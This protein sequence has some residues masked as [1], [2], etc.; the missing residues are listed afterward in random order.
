MDGNLCCLDAQLL[1]LLL[2]LFKGHLLLL[3][4]LA[5]ES[6]LVAIWSLASQQPEDVCCLS[7]IVLLTEAEG[8]GHPPVC[9]LRVFFSRCIPPCLA[10]RLTAI[11]VHYSLFLWLPSA[12]W[13]IVEGGRQRTRKWFTASTD[14]ALSLLIASGDKIFGLPEKSD[15]RRKFG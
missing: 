1:I 7:P 14:D 3:P 9:K 8:R 11:A 12:T 10:Q 5:G 2:V 15:Q 6:L 4:T 13:C